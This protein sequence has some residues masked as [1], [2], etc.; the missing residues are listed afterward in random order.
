MTETK[1]YTSQVKDFLKRRGH[2]VQRFEQEGIPDIYTVKDGKVLW[3]ELKV[4]PVHWRL[5]QLAW[6]SMNEEHGGNTA[7]CLWYKKEIF[8]LKPQLTYRVEEV[9]N[10]RSKETFNGYRNFV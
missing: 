5:G 8:F 1:M 9:E 6:I 4:W 2:F 3:I 7:L 10:T